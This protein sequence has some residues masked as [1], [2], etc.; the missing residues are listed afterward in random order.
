MRKKPREL[1]FKKKNFKFHC[2]LGGRGMC[3]LS[4]PTSLNMRLF[5]A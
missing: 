4:F 1:F 2:K 3:K 5:C